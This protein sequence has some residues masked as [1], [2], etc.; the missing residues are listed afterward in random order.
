MKNGAIP[1]PLFPIA[2]GSFQAWRFCFLL[3]IGVFY[4]NQLLP[5]ILKIDLLIFFASII[6]VPVAMRAG[7]FKKNIA[8]CPP[9]GCY[10]Q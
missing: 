5:S 4:V 3:S 8:D 2:A 6:I 7:V 1:L 9:V 10:Y